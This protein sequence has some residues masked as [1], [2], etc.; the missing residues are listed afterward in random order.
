MNKIYPVTEVKA[1]GKPCWSEGG[2]CLLF[3]YSKN[4]GNFILK[5][6]FAE[7]TK[8]LEKNYTHYFY[9]LSLWHDGKSRGYWRF[10]K[11]AVTIYQ[12]NKRAKAFKY[13]VVKYNRMSMYMDN[14]IEAEL[15][16]K[17]MPNHWI[18]EFDKL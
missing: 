13:R 10:W 16:Y 6:Y 15:K 2:Y 17:R 9:Y 1:S 7:V 5:G 14:K 4:D 3:V 8:F 11:D 18:P 12:P